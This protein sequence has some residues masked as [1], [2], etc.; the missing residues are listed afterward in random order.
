MKG[1]VDIQNLYFA[2]SIEMSKAIGLNYTTKAGE[3]VLGKNVTA[4]I[5]YLVEPLPRSAEPYLD[6]RGI[7]IRYQGEIVGAHID[8]GRHSGNMYTLSG[9]SFEEVT[10]LIPSIY[11][12]QTV[13]REFERGYS[14][15]EELITNYFKAQVEGDVTTYF[16]TISTAKW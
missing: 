8:T 15:D 16:K 6:A 4:E 14:S 5:Y 1:T 10:E 13:M 12:A 9:K 11:L 3:E 2:L 7:V